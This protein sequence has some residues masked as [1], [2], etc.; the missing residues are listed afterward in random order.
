[1]CRISETQRSLGHVFKLPNNRLPE[2]LLFG[3]VKT[4]CPPGRPRSNFNDVAL[5]DCHTVALVAAHW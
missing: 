5:R 1:M 2:K 4:L 3:E